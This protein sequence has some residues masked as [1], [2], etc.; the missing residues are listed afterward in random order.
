MAKINKKMTINVGV[1][2]E[3]RNHLFS[4]VGSVQ[5]FTL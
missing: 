4:G 3:K 2:M 5:T 1:D